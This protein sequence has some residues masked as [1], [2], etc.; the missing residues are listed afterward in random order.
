MGPTLQHK[1][2][3]HLSLTQIQLHIQTAYKFKETVLMQSDAFD[4]ERSSAED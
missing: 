4:S 2:S 1:S 3:S